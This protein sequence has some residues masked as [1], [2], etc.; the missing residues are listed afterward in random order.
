MVMGKNAKRPQSLCYSDLLRMI[1]YETMRGIIL[2]GDK[3]WRRKYTSLRTYSPTFLDSFIEELQEINACL[4][5]FGAL[6]TS[7]GW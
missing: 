4:L 6:P 1:N 2:P 7:G 5:T 3:T